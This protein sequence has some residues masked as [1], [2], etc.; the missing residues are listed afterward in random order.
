MNVREAADLASASFTVR[1]IAV[2]AI[3]AGQTER[4]HA[5]KLLALLEHDLW[6]IFEVSMGVDTQ[7]T[8]LSRLGHMLSYIF[9]GTG[10]RGSF[11]TPQLYHDLQAIVKNAF[12]CA[13]KVGVLWWSVCACD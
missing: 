5:E 3:P 4:W 1:S 2:A 12:F 9:I 11:L 13:A 10:N 7:L 6:C 8:N